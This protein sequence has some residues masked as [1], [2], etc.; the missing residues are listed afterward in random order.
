MSDIID[1]SNIEKSWYLWK[2]M[3]LS[4]ADM[5]IPQ[6]QLSCKHHLP[7]MNSEIRGLMRKRNRLFKRAK[8]SNSIAHWGKYRF[9]RREVKH[10]LHKSHTE[11]VAC[12]TANVKQNPKKFWNYVKACKNVTTRAEC[13]KRNG[14]IMT[15]DKDKTEI[16]NNQFNSAFRTEIPV[17]IPT[18]ESYD[19]PVMNDINCSVYEVCKLLKN[20]DVNKAQGPDGI[21][22]KILKE[23]AEPLSLSLC[24]LFNLSLTTGE[25]PEDWRKAKS[26]QCL[27]RVKRMTLQTTDLFPLHQSQ[28]NYL[29]KSSPITS[30]NI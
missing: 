20:I 11:Y 10:R 1:S 13:L 27:K 30:P 3:V 17:R 15:D 16:L 23:G 28:A 24:M 7:W 5:N 2:T 29:K 18:T 6:K 21:A 22:P 9:L 25:V 14:N 19:I 4:I 12:T 26:V 8:I